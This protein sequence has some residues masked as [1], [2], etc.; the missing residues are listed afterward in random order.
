M[1]LILSRS[2]NISCKTWG[3]FNNCDIVSIGK[4][5]ID[6]NDFFCL[7]DYVLTNTDLYK[8]DPRLKFIARVKKMKKVK[9]YMKGNKHLE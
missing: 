7:V 9:G 6:I 5:D 3:L 4:Y 1:S 8:N 2:K